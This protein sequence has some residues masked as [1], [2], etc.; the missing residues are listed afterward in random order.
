MFQIRDLPLSVVYSWSTDLNKKVR[1]A[2]LRT[3]LSA[4]FAQGDIEVVD[5][6]GLFWDVVLDIMVC[7]WS[8]SG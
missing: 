6:A 3:A 2:G 4:K 8:A 5:A 1:R 7:G